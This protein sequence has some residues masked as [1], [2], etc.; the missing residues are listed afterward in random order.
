MW[1]EDPTNPDK[2][3][4]E[5]Q[6][7]YEA[8]GGK[9]GWPMLRHP[10][11]FAVPFLSWKTAN[12]QFDAKQKHVNELIAQGK[13][14][15]AIWFYE[16]P[17]RISLLIEWFNFGLLSTT[18]LTELLPEIWISTEFPYSNAGGYRRILK[19]FKETGFVTD[20]PDHQVPDEPIIF[21]G[22][23]PK[24]QRGMSWTFNPRKAAWF[25]QRFDQDG[26][27]YTARITKEGVLGLFLGRDEDEVVVN[28]RKLVDV[29]ELSSFD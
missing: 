28:P 16:K 11:V 24:Y 29:K 15:E 18:Q 1:G 4:P 13:R 3:Y 9:L 17:Y 23:S 22:C 26:K 27:V 6:L 14:A 20:A 5:L 19:L 2:L 10:L 7:Y 21:R 25:A 12:T 8:K